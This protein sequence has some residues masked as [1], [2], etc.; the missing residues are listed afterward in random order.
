[1]SAI[2]D[3]AFALCTGLTEVTVPGSA[4]TLGDEV[5]A[6]CTGLE[7]ATFEEGV[8]TTA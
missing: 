7:T 3:R 8:E 5:F 1:M 2:G 4:K 6:S